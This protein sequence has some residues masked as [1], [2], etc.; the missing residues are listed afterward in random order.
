[1]GFSLS[2][3]VAACLPASP[4]ILVWVTVCTAASRGLVLRQPCGAAGVSLFTLVL[5]HVPARGDENLGKPT[6]FHSV[7]QPSLFFRDAVAFAGC[8][9]RP[10]A[11]VNALDSTQRRSVCRDHAIHAAASFARAR[12]VP[13]A[14]A[15][16]AHT[17]HGG[18]DGESEAEADMS[19]G[20]ACF[21]ARRRTRTRHAH[22]ARTEDGRGPPRR[23]IAGEKRRRHLMHSRRVSLRASD[24]Q[25]VDAGA[26]C[27]FFRQERF[28]EL[29]E[30]KADRPPSPA[31]RRLFS[32][33]L[34][35]SRSP[36][37]TDEMRSIACLS[38][39]GYGLGSGPF[40]RQ[41]R[42]LDFP[43]PLAL[44]GHLPL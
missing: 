41:P 38:I 44:I 18:V 40:H 28:R 35:P 12:W 6:S 13:A 9:P 25:V 11:N 34:T 42:T 30:R 24:T 43:A 20:H 16:A 23:G 19:L 2:P 33:L 5:V 7:H 22:M 27:F 1:M 10:R 37:A 8:D 17:S 29:R 36:P 39:S 14:A 3:C 32:A 15:R 31:G 4:V 21:L 26:W